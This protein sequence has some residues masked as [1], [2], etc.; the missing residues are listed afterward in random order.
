M[1]DWVGQ[2]VSKVLIERRLARGSMAEVYLGR[3]MTLNQPMVVKILYAH[4]SEDLEL[5]KRFR[6]EAQAV[7]TLHHPN[8]V[9]VF[10]FD[11]LDGR[12][13][14]IM[15][16]IEGISL[17][18]YLASLP[19]AG[20]RMP[21]TATV[22]IIGQLAE[23]LD[24]AHAEG[25]LHRDIKPANV[26]LRNGGSKVRQGEPLP[27]ETQPVLT[28][29]GLARLTFAPEHTA[30]GTV[31]GT[32]AYMSPE[33]VEGGAVDERSDIYA[34]GVLAYEMLCGSRPFESEDDSAAS[35]MYMQVHAQPPPLRGAGK[36]LQ[37]FIS[38]ALAKDP[39]DRYPQAS[40]LASE[41]KEAIRYDSTPRP[42][43]A[44]LQVPMRVWASALAALLLT[45]A[46]LLGLR[47]DR[48]AGAEPE[49]TPQPAVLAADTEMPAA[50]VAP[51]T[52]TPTAFPSPT[53][54]PTL[55]VD[56]RAH[57]DL[58]EPDI[59]DSF[60]QG[61][62]WS[63]Y[64]LADRSAYQVENG[65][66]VGT[67][68]VPEERYTWWSMD[69]R[70]SGNLYAEVSTT[71]G[72]CLGKDSVGI[73]IRVDPDSGMGGYSF[74][75]SCD[76]HWRL[77]RHHR[78]GSPRVLVDWSEA[79][80]INTGLGAVNRLGVLAY[81][82][83]FVLYVNDQQVGTVIDPQYTYSFGAF[84]LYVRASLTYSLQA[85]FDNFSAWHIRA[86]PWD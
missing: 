40:Q 13:Y 51:P 1:R 11:S 12:P 46:T 18:T 48:S 79:A 67:D 58:A 6:T 63:T 3:H 41:L 52:S 17:E 86:V 27:A 71:N 53:P 81:L 56:P 7:A 70:Q 64:D 49:R 77:R 34:L 80:A 60:S 30:P 20:R 59:S 57:L 35:T 61:T 62:S 50:L 23:A 28:D 16:L 55:A 32:P 22:H 85:S 9:R 39:S 66:L 78:D 42:W 14:I 47:G 54:L 29:F 2:V 74:E 72:D 69:W 45:A 73:A 15:E 8:I 75:V 82:D 4:L 84:A 26:M 38:R 76:G 37:R 24:Y 68:Y 83:R 5:L 44:R 31:M 10:D 21:Y 25:V 36:H 65:M 43:Y 33:Q 19:A